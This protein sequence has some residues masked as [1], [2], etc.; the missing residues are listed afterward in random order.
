MLHASLKAAHRMPAINAV[1]IRNAIRIR[2]M[3]NDGLR[4]ERLDMQG[5]SL[6]AVYPLY[7]YKQRDSANAAMDAVVAA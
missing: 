7:A 2:F 4:A 5:V 3:S 6:Q 1:G